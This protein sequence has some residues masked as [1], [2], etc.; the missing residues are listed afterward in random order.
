MLHNALS[1]QWSILTF[2]NLD[3]ANGVNAIASKP[4]GLM[5]KPRCNQTVPCLLGRFLE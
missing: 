3:R 4:L 2:P 1:I 5:R